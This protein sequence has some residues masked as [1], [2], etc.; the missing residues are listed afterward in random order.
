LGLNDKTN[1]TTWKQTIHF[2]DNGYYKIE[3]VFLFQPPEFNKITIS[4]L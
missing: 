1:C 2:Q 4:H 3:R